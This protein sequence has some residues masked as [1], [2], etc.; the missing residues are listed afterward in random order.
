VQIAFANE[1]A[2]ICEGVGGDVWRVRQ[3]VNKSPQRYMHLPGWGVGG[4]CIP[5]DP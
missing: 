1:V 3:L 5:K 4:H 2:L